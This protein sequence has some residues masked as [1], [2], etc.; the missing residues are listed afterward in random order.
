MKY[1]Q[2]FVCLFRKSPA[3]RPRMTLPTH[4][5]PE[6]PRA[7]VFSTAFRPEGQRPGLGIAQMVATAIDTLLLVDPEN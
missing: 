1:P 5:R 7:T 2:R 3:L 6:H 4:T